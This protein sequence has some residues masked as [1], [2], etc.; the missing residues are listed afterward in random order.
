[1]LAGIAGGGVQ[2]TALRPQD[3]SRKELTLAYSTSE[4]VVIG[5]IPGIE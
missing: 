1:M 3:Q 4:K 2:D 5:L